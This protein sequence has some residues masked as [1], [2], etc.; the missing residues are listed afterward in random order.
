MTI[1]KVSIPKGSIKSIAI[2]GGGASGAVI[3][4]SLIKQQSFDEIVVF[5][6]KK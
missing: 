2:I 1:D 5:E 6:K 3:L 4:D